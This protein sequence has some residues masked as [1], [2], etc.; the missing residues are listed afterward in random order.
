MY[1]Y[2]FYAV[3]GK[4][5]WFIVQLEDESKLHSKIFYKTKKKTVKSNNI[6]ILFCKKSTQLK[7]VLPQL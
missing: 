6:Y 4:S 2:L 5:N 1:V 3:K 7:S